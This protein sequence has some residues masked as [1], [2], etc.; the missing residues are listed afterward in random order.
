MKREAFPKADPVELQI[1]RALRPG[2]FIYDR[3]C[4][5]FV[6]GLKEVAA[7]IEKLITDEPA[8][9]AA[10][11]E[12]F[13]AGCH[14]KA[15]QLDDSSANFG[16]FVKD[17]ICI[18]IK[19]NQAGGADPDKTAATLL[20]WMDDDPYSFFHEIEKDASAAFDEAGLTAFEKQV[21]ARFAAVADDPSSWPYR[22]LSVV[23]RTV[24]LAQKNIL[25]YM[26]HAERTGLTLEDCLAIAKLLA[27]RKPPDALAWVE[28]GLAWRERSS[29]PPVRPAISKISIVNSWSRW[30]VGRRRSKLPGQIFKGIPRNTAMRT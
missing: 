4:F 12:A 30:A 25:A 7:E 21:R 6:G 2:E 29:F 5:A 16:M 24:Y 1:K 27:D 17:L 14:A 20:S 10:L 8:R 15:E 11:C 3:A 22:C 23:L 18:W 13:L 19:A 26:E 9:A 28:R